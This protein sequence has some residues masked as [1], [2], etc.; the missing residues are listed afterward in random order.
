VRQ[1]AFAILIVCVMAGC[2]NERQ[3]PPGRGAAF[4]PGPEG[5]A[6]TTEQAGATGG[7]DDD[8]V[9]PFSA[10]EDR[11]MFEKA[12][13]ET[14]HV[15]R[16]VETEEAEPER[17]LSDELRDLL[18]DPTSC[19]GPDEPHRD[20]TIRVTVTVV[21]SG[22]VTRSSAQGPLSDE[23]KRCV[24]DR[25]GAVRFSAPVPDSPRNV[26]TSVTARW[27]DSE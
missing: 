14:V 22:M 8:R 7:E 24:R 15:K 23:A 18:G 1:A 13:P 12:A 10:P 21:E 27:T 11:P 2:G 3:A 26:S 25:A 16:Q 19:F 17:N 5:S 4:D 20:I 6:N 9:D